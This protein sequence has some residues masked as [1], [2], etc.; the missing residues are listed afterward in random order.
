MLS[1]RKTKKYRLT[2]FP[3]C[4]V[5]HLGS[6]A[7]CGIITI[8]LRYCAQLVAAGLV[9]CEPGTGPRLSSYTTTEVGRSFRSVSVCPHRAQ[10]S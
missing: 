8:V 10:L 6:I 2:S 1:G 4:I 3:V 5:Q 9:K 7:S